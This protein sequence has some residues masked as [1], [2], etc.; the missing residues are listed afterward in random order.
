MKLL[1]LALGALSLCA[2]VMRAA[3][4]A[5][6]K[7]TAAAR[8]DERAKWWMESGISQRAT[9]A[10]GK[11]ACLSCHTTVPYALARPL[12]A[13]AMASA[14][15]TPLDRLLQNIDRRLETWDTHAELYEFDEDKKR[16]SRGTEAVLSALIL[17]WGE[18]ARHE[19]APS[20]KTKKAF[21]QLWKTQRQDGSWDW[22]RFS[23]EPWETK[24]SQYHG[25]A[26][27]AFAIGVA[28]GYYTAGS[29]PELEQKVERLT[30]YLRA[31]RDKKN[32]HSEVWLLLASTKLKGVLTQEEQTQ[33][34]DT[35]KEK[36]R[37]LGDGAGGWVLLELSDWRYNAAAP[38]KTPPLLNPEAKN[39][40]GYATGLMT[41]ALLQ[42]GIKAN[43]AKVA[44]ALRWLNQ[45]Q[46]ADGSWP[47]V[48][49]NVDRKRG[50]VAEFFMSDA[51]T[52][53]AVIALLEA[54]MTK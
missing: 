44:A 50:N 43:D 48:S 20:L 12:L 53:W 10:K 8:L 41:Y 27:A 22:F 47:A 31:N 3:E 29:S 4:P 11:T 26:Q 51:A 25:A 37:S 49:I 38:P 39:P 21:D 30:K 18:A 34:I 6:N 54:E 15:T 35:L 2:P 28:P 16:E 14:E 32:L 23:F 17:A 5:W 9:D 7:K 52:S 40:D 36:Q 13:K 46:K 1:V 24:D 45:N 19:T 42:A 33:V